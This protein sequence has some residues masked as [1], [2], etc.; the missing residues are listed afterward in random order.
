MEQNNY[1]GSEQNNSMNSEAQTPQP[2]NSNASFQNNYSQ[3]DAP[4]EV[5]PQNYYASSESYYNRQEMAP[6]ITLGDFFIMFLVMII[7][8]VN[9]IMLFVWGFSSDTNP[10]KSNYCKAQ[11][12][13]IAIGIVVSMLF[14]GLII[15][16][17][18]AAFQSQEMAMLF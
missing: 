1:N 15:A 5:P 17:L 16:I 14:W 2:D 10:N 8:V 9:I 6:P 7:P 13:L 4:R 3:T 12:I 18:V 11:L